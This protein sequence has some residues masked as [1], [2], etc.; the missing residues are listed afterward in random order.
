MMFWA[1]VAVIVAFGFG[2]LTGASAAA[3]RVTD[4]LRERDALRQDRAT[5]K[6]VARG[7]EARIEE[8]RE[9]EQV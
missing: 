3:G 7:Y 9:R 4:L 6:A 1:V 5:W 2:L 8:M